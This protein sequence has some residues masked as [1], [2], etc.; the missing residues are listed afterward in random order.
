[1]GKWWQRQAADR[2]GRAALGAALAG[3]LALAFL[4]LGS[5]AVLDLAPVRNIDQDVATWFY[6]HDNP[7]V[8]D[9]FAVITDLGSPVL[10]ALG[11]GLSLY[12][13]VRRQWTLLAGWALAMGAGKLWNEALKDWLARP[14]PTFPGWENPA[15]G[16]GFPSGHTMQAMLAYGMLVYLGWARVRARGLLLSGAIVLIALIALSRLVLVAHYP[17]DVVGGLLAGGIWLLT[18]LAF[19]EALRTRQATQH[20]PDRSETEQEAP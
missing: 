15:D 6:Q 4:A 13:L 3:C 2:P 5:A 7:S 9:I 8:R 1:M 20:S 14:R 19:T 12:L 16:Y 17:S 11:I 18:S 10:W